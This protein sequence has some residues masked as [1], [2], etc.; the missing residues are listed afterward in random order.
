MRDADKRNLNIWGKPKRVQIIG[1]CIMCAAASFVCVHLIWWLC[2]NAWCLHALVADAIQHPN[3]PHTCHITAAIHTRTYAWPWCAVAKRFVFLFQI[4]CGRSLIV[5]AWPRLS[6]KLFHW[7]RIDSLPITT[8]YNIFRVGYHITVGCV[9]TVHSRSDESHMTDTGACLSWDV[10]LEAIYLLT[11]LEKQLQQ[12]MP[13]RRRWIEYRKWHAICDRGQ[14]VDGEKF[15]T[16][17]HTH[18]HTYIY[19]YF[20]TAVTLFPRATAVTLSLRRAWSLPTTSSVLRFSCVPFQLRRSGWGEEKK[21]DM[22]ANYSIGGWDHFYRYAELWKETKKKQPATRRNE[23]E[24]HVI[25]ERRLCPRTELPFSITM[26]VDSGLEISKY[27]CNKFGW[28]EN[29]WRAA[30]GI[31]QTNSER[32]LVTLI[33][34]YMLISLHKIAVN[35]VLVITR[36][37]CDSISDDAHCEHMCAQYLF[38]PHRV[39]SSCAVGN[40]I[41][42]TLFPSVWIQIRFWTGPN[43]DVQG[44]ENQRRIVFKRQR[45]ICNVCDKTNECHWEESCTMWISCRTSNIITNGIQLYMHSFYGV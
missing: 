34:T 10:K 36:S 9:C 8:W 6:R 24:D 40:A 37:T 21:V 20:S 42:S 41:F 2:T 22:K 32:A 13:W 5:L 1:W 27:W 19:I 12:R 25:H 44:E 7:Y 26:H 30:S 39:H 11:K 33:Y 18:T 28:R 38:T 14:V 16:Y 43:I 31:P 29:S 17:T 35:R 3:H 4:E 15:F 23:E 45:I